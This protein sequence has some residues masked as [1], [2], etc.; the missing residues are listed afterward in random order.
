M[1]SNSFDPCTPHYCSGSTCQRRPL[2]LIPLPCAAWP[3]PPARAVAG[4]LPPA[5]RPAVVCPAPS[6][7]SLSLSEWCFTG[8]S[9]LPFPSHRHPIKK[10]T[11]GPH[12]LS[13]LPLSTLSP[14]SNRVNVRLPRPPRPPVRGLTAGEPHLSSFEAE[15]C[16]H[17][18]LPGERRAL[19]VFRHFSMRLTSSSSSSC[20]RTTPRHLWPPPAI[21]CRWTSLFPRRWATPLSSKP[22]GETSPTSPCPRG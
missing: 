22:V 5:C 15:S 10:A 12:A 11:T 18:H 13:P 20:C 2:L 17:F 16:R 7:P 3:P 9:P 1:D 14:P 8:L 4:P 6:P 19:A 21:H